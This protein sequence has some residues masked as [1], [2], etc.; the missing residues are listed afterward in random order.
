MGLVRRLLIS[1]VIA[2]CHKRHEERCPGGSAKQEFVVADAQTSPVNKQSPSEGMKSL[3]S[4]NE[5][6]MGPQRGIYIP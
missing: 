3:L 4:S 1:L 6:K 2:P 5:G